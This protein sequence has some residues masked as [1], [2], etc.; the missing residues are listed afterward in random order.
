MAPRPPRPHEGCARAGGRRLSGRPVP[1]GAE[2]FGGLAYGPAWGTDG[3][4]GRWLWMFSGL[5]IKQEPR[6][7]EGAA[8]ARTGVQ[9]ASG[10]KR[11]NRSDRIVAKLGLHHSF[12][13]PRAPAQRITNGES[14][15]SI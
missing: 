5:R 12:R 14:I 3:R 7:L 4:D 1:A 2:A 6:L 13:S 8:G 11:A 9:Y 15:A 10:T